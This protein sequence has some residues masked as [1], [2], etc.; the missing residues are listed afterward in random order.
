MR[1]IE[2]IGHEYYSPAVLDD[3]G[4]KLVVAEVSDP[5]VAANLRCGTLSVRVDLLEKKIQGLRSGAH[6]LVQW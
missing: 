4:L 3:T 6:A 1:G 2:V 5:K